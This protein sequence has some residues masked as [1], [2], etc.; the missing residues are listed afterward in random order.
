M[1]L[2][3]VLNNYALMVLTQTIHALTDSTRQL[4]RKLA[5]AIHAF[6]G[7]TRQLSPNSTCLDNSCPC[8]QYSTVIP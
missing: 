1:P 6:G 4:C 3:A 8:M 2:L 5:Q 7:S